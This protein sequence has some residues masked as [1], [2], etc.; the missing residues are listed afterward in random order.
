MLANL[1]T[2]T[3][4]HCVGPCFD[5]RGRPA[6]TQLRQC[7]QHGFLLEFPC[8]AD[9]KSA[10]ARTGRSRSVA[11][12]FC[13]ATPV[14]ISMAMAQQQRRFFISQSVMQDAA[15]MLTRRGQ[16]RVV[17]ASRWLTPAGGFIA[18]S[19]AAH[20]SHGVRSLLSGV[21]LCAIFEFTGKCG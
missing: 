12:S 21:Q 20:Q 19:W 1:Q 14:S 10:S 2:L 3:P 7:G 8:P 16:T 4:K 18:M 17:L 6:A 13:P 11:W 9:R 15:L 5:N